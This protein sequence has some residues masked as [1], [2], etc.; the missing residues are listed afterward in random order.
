MSLAC[1]GACVATGL[2]LVEAPPAFG[3]WVLWCVGEFC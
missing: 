3:A 1:Y 2:E